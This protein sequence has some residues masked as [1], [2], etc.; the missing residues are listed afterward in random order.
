MFVETIASEKPVPA[1]FT[2]FQLFSWFPRN[3][4]SAELSPEAGF[5][6]APPDGICLDADGAVWVADPIAKRFYRVLE[7]G[8]VTDVIRPPNGANA[9]ACT[10]GGPERRT[11]I[12]A[13]SDAL[14]GREPLPAG[15]ARLD[16]LVVDVPGAGRP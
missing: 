7:G 9:I 13:V 16:G 4:N 3:W 12:M 10:L 8:E 1:A 6:Y 11:L 5:A 2:V 15:N 14:P